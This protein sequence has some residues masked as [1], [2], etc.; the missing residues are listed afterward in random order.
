M[1][2]ASC[3]DDSF[4]CQFRAYRLAFQLSCYY[5]K[6]VF[7]ITHEKARTKELDDYFALK[8]HPLQVMMVV[9]R[10]YKAEPECDPKV[11]LYDA[12]RD[13]MPCTRVFLIPVVL[14]PI[15][16]PWLDPQEKQNRLDNGA[17]Q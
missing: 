3:W 6:Q 14:V 7:V 1:I 15:V 10:S 13:R 12:W 9:G 11:T 17:D 5:Q 8:F 4:A 2:F 16:F